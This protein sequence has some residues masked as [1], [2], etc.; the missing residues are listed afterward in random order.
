LGDY[1]AKSAR[2]ARP[3]QSQVN[4][5]RYHTERII[6]MQ[7]SENEVSSHRGLHGNARGFQVPD[8]PDEHH[9]RILPE[10]RPK[11]R[12]KGYATLWL[13]LDLGNAGELVFDRIFDRH[14]VDFTRGELANRGVQ[15]RR[16]AGSCWAR[17]DYYAFPEGQH[18]P[19]AP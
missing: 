4:E 3:I 19:E 2:Y 1:P 14:D 12:R 17:H 9:I 10:N 18:L 13:D 7:G 11:R 15:R 16:F 8:L 5:P 6:R